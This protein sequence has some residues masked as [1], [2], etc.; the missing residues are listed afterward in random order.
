LKVNSVFEKTPE[1]G[2]SELIVI[3]HKEPL[4]LMVP[5]FLK[6]IVFS[7]STEENVP[8]PSPGSAYISI[9]FQLIQYQSLNHLYCKKIKH[10]L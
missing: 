1:V 5:S 4:E 2:L 8:L 3:S 9:N 10:L 7:L 6:V